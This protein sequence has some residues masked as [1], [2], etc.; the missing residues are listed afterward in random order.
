MGRVQTLMSAFFASREEKASSPLS[1]SGLVDQALDHVWRAYVCNV[2]G[3]ARAD[4]FDIG[5]ACGRRRPGSGIE[6][7]SCHKSWRMSPI[8]SMPSDIDIV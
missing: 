4:S 5:S 8:S 1:V 2:S 3:P 7:D 6:K